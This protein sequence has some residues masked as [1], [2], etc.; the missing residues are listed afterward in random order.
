MK[1]VEIL[2]IKKY[3]EFNR[4]VVDWQNF[5][6]ISPSEYISRLTCIE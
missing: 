1:K 3:T 5:N 2:D 6:K 4:N